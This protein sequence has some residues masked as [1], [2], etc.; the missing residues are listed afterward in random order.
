MR[1]WGRTPDG[2]WHEITT[3]TKGYN[4]RVWFVTLCQALLLNLGESP[5]F[6]NYGIP[7]Q[8]SVMQQIYPDFYVAMTQQQ[9]APYFANLS[10]AREQG[11]NPVYNVRAL[12]QTGASLFDTVPIPS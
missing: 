12:A 4:D 8:Q 3:D 11:R 7:A 2:T 1:T 10:V 6:A 5:F 9:F